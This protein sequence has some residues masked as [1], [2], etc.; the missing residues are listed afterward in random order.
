M[1]ETLYNKLK[2]WLYLK[3]SNIFRHDY[4]CCSNAFRNCKKCEY[5]KDLEI[6]RLAEYENGRR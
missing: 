5:C 3:I 1:K 2:R 6:Q 4:G